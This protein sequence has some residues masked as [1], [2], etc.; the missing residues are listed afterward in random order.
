MSSITGI[1]TP[2]STPRWVA[3]AALAISLLIPLSARADHERNQT[4]EIIAGAAVVYALFDAAGAFDDDR[5]HHRHK[6]HGYRHD[7]YYR[8]DRY[9]RHHNRHYKRPHHYKG[10]VKHRGY[11]RYRGHDRHRGYDKHSYRNK[12]HNNKHYNRHKRHGDRYTAYRH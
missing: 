4:F 3:A 10:H 6:R 5:H 2:G 7:G 8:N 12:H 9:A 1:F 11:D